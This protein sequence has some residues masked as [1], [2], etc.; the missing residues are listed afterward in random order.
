MIMGDVYRGVG[1]HA[2]GLVI[3]APLAL[4]YRGA[5]T[6]AKGPD[7]REIQ[8]P[9]TVLKQYQR[10]EAQG[11]WRAAPDAQRRDIIVSIGDATL[12]FSD[13]NG[14]AL[15][16]WSLPAIERISPPGTLPALY[17]PAPDAF[18]TLELSD[19]T[20]IDAL[21][22]VHSAIAR[23]RPRSGRLR[24]V[25]LS[26]G[27]AAVIALGLIWGPDALVRHTVSVVPMAK[28]AEIGQSVLAVIRQNAGPR[29]EIPQASRALARL[30]TRLL[31]AAGRGEIVVLS[32]AIARSEHL[33]GGIILLNRALIETPEDPA[34][35]AGY[36]LTEDLRARN[37]DPLER[38]LRSAGPVASFRLLTTGALPEDVITAYAAELMQAPP[39]APD[40]DALAARFA[41][42]A[43]DPAP[44]AAAIGTAIA[45]A[46]VATRP[47]I[48]DGE[49]VALQGICGD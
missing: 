29:C 47:L 4:S 48:S 31:P 27:L 18:E 46:P 12:V 28:R 14:V 13:Y 26:S 39:P 21:G 33:P 36:I 49:W 3:V 8:A 6:S 10:L 30:R 17:R 24:N 35:T 40:A 7:E 11:L 15:A 1:G 42:A 44:F 32:G 2:S 34:V 43:L 25:L 9:M 20:M 37:L 5:K 41:D 22:K 23:A 19:E 16:H 38:L 45:S